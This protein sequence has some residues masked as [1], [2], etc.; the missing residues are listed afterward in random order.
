MYVM[1]PPPP[2]NAGFSMPMFKTFVPESLR[3]WLYVL[4]AFCFQFSVFKRIL[5]RFTRRHTRGNKLYD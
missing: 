4:T 2:A 3:P 5:L 1:P